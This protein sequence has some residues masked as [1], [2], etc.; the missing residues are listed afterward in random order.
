MFYRLDPLKTCLHLRCKQML[1]G[2]ERSQE[3]QDYLEK[4]YGKCDTTVYWCDRTQTGRGPDQQ[5][6]NSTECTKE[7]PCFVGIESLKEA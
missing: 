6:A 5:R 7:R 4:H 2:A 3:E 1:Y